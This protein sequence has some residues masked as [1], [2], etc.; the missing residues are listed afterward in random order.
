MDVVRL[1]AHVVCA[2]KTFILHSWCR[3]SKCLRV[4]NDSKRFTVVVVDVNSVRTFFINGNDKK[5]AATSKQA[6]LI[7]QHELL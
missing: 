4:F 5:L 1:N 3:D 6:F 7:N 2:T